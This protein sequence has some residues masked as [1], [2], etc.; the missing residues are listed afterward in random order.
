MKKYSAFLA[1]LVISF[2]IWTIYNLSRT[3]SDV[4]SVPVVARSNLEGY[5]AE[6]AKPASISARCR[7][8]GF[9]LIPLSARNRKPV[10]VYFDPSDFTMQDD[11][12]FSIPSSYVHK[13][14]E[15]IFGSGVIIE[16]LVSQDII[17]RF[18]EESNKKVPV[19]PVQTLSFRPQYMPVGDLKIVPDSI[20][21]YGD[22]DLISSI[23][24]VL[25]FP[26]NLND[27]HS[28]ESGVVK[29][30]RMRGVRLSEEEANYY[31]TVTRFVEITSE[32]PIELR[33]VPQ[34]KGISIYP[35]TA[36]VI[37]NCSFPLLGNPSESAVLYVD[38]NEFIGSLSGKCLIHC[39]R[40][41]KGILSYNIE[42]QVCE[43]FET[44]E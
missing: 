15:Q 16:N 29:I 39:D 28:D 9:K 21:V 11:G 7:T 25:T 33:N 37:F 12:M 19:V 10:T 30:D 22:S 24:K 42:P 17:F 2:G 3:S 26:I 43:C 35:G 36:K 5:A 44:V 32:F 8:T 27:I 41:P 14:S 4:V 20:V 38:Y 34:G 18:T 31:I 23:D 6:S 40:L 1:C 13:Y